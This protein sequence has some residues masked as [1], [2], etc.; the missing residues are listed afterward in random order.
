MRM[1]IRAIFQLIVSFLIYDS[2][3][4]CTGWAKWSF[5]DFQVIEDDSLEGKGREG[6]G[7]E[8]KGRQG[9]A[10]EGKGRQGKAREGKGRQGKGRE[11]FIIGKL[12]LPLPGLNKIVLVTTK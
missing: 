2:R 1:L 6:K 12:D 7:R 9:K 8:G 4:R 11:I 5:E 3:D 10:R